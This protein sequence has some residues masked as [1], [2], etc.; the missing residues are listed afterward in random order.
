MSDPNDRRLQFD[1]GAAV[2]ATCVAPAAAEPD[3]SFQ[4]RFVSRLEEACARLR[5]DPKSSSYTL[6][7]LTLC[8]ELLT[9]FTVASGQ[10]RPV[11]G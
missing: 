1:L 3:R 4:L 8:R 10:G 2:V 5:G 9:G 11:L 7:E 6:G